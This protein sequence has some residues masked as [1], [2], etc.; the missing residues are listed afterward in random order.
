MKMRNLQNYKKSNVIL[1]PI[2]SY[3]NGEN[4]AS[5]NGPSLSNQKRRKCPFDHT[6]MMKRKSVYNNPIESNMREYRS[7]TPSPWE[8]V[9]Q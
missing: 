7:Y 5:S 8:V 2:V 9:C 1:P 3:G 4:G 6:A